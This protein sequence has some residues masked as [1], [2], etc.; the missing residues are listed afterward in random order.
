[1]RI[2]TRPFAHALTLGLLLALGPVTTTHAAPGDA[3]AATT[4]RDTYQARGRHIGVAVLAHK[5]GDPVYTGI[6]DR[7][8]GSVT[9]ETELEW[10]SVEPLPGQFVFTRAD[11]IVAHAAANGMAVRGRSLISPAGVHSAWFA[12]LRDAA[13]VHAAMSRH[14]TG[15]LTHYRGQVHSWGVVTEAFTDTG[16]PRRSPF[17]VYLGHSFIEQAFRIARAADPTATLCYNDYNLDD[18]HKPKTQAVYTM[19]RD[20]L[21]R[22]V[23][24]DCVGLQSHF[25]AGNPVPADYQRT[26]A[27]FAALGIEVQISELGV[28]GS[29]QAQAESYRRVA[30]ACLATPR[31]SGLTVWG[32]RDSDTWRTSDTPVLFDGAGNPKPA[33]YAV[34]YP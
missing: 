14:I 11:Q 33:Y 22:G 12:N 9:P 7:E 34:L 27:E 28:A 29:G 32:V 3:V 23:P 2:R 4:L 30:L 1:M 19:V 15:V 26:L 8:F 5:L 18:F 10:D 20:F 31:C 13:S 21:A 24:I 6:L 25:T 16:A 17:E